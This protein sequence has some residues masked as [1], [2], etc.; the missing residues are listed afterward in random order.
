M[1]PTLNQ[2]GTGHRAERVAEPCT[3]AGALKAR[4]LN[5][6]GAAESDR[7]E[8]L[9]DDLWETGR[10][11]IRRAPRTGLIMAGVRDSFDTPFYL[12][13]VLV[14][15]AEVACDGQPGYGLL[16]G[17][18]PERALLL[19]AVEAAAVQGH[20]ALLKG[21]RRFIDNLEA[22]ALEQSEQQSRLTAATRVRFA[23]M[24]KENVDFGSLGE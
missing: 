15:E 5:V 13:E 17:D 1:R 19:A 16:C 9:L 24:K 6:I 14:S 3:G 7:I 18:E 2:S 21:V 4:L 22:T 8:A 12:G 10:F 20:T 23:S 11:Q